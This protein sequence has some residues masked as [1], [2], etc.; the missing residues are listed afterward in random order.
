MRKILAPLLLLI[1]LALFA[2][3][4]NITFN[5]TFATTTTDN[6]SL[7]Q[8]INSL[9]QEISGLKK[10]SSKDTALIITNIT[11]AIIA[12]LSFISS[13]YFYNKERKYREILYD[14]HFVF[15]FE[16]TRL[17]KSQLN[18]ESGD[19]KQ[20]GYSYPN[21]IRIKNI[22]IVFAEIEFFVLNIMGENFTLQISEKNK[23]K[24]DEKTYVL[25]SDEVEKAIEKEL[26]GLKGG[27]KK[28]ESYLNKSGV[29]ITIKYRTVFRRNNIEKLEFIC[30][31]LSNGIEFHKK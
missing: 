24:P 14:A 13:L 26:D 16:E 17:H 25:L 4:V 30:H 21:M 3:P 27:Y 28:M 19:Y 2:E 20:T 5:N 29:S 23:L 1:T 7:V 11:L 8:T 9:K 22:G 31:S 6:A 10:W 15:S 18:T 12:V